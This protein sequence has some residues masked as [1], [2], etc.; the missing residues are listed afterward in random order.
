MSHIL[1]ISH[2]HVNQSCKS[3]F[4][5]FSFAELNKKVRQTKM[6]SHVYQTFRPSIA[7]L[8]LIIFVVY[9]FTFITLTRLARSASSSFISI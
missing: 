9:S 3:N 6:T 1:Y 7:G 4:S 8:F 5:T 2:E